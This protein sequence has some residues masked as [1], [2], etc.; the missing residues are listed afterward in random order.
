MPGVPERRTSTL[1]EKA[2][3]ARAEAAAPRQDPVTVLG[4]SRS[5]DMYRLSRRGTRSDCLLSTE[6]GRS[7]DLE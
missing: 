5:A 2:E 6:L 4:G 1:H 7:A 3:R